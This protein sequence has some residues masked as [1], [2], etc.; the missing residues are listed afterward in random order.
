V[1]SH[2]LEDDVV[3]ADLTAE[4]IELSSGR[5]YLKARRPELYA[6]LVEPQVSVT[7][8]GWRLAHEQRAEVREQDSDL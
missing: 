8:P 3:V 2:A 5:R 6:K 7:L 1:E 4:K